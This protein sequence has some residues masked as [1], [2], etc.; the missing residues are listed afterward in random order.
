M[1][2]QVKLNGPSAQRLL[3]DFATGQ[4]ISVMTKDSAITVEDAVGNVLTD[5]AEAGWPGTVMIT[6]EEI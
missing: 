2:M 1:T 5:P 6:E 3:V 4:T